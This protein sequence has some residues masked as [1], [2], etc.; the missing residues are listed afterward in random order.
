M[1]DCGCIQIYGEI[2]TE[3]EPTC[4]ENNGW[5]NPHTFKVANRFK[6]VGNGK[7]LSVSLTGKDYLSSPTGSSEDRIVVMMSQA[8]WIDKSYRNNRSQLELFA[9]IG[10]TLYMDSVSGKVEGFR[11]YLNLTRLMINPAVKLPTIK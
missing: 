5:N 2:I 8:E 4:L 10:Q 3:L 7:V 9:D 11:N 1:T 6:R